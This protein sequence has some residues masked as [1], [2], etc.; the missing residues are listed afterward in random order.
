MEREKIIYDRKNGLLGEAGAQEPQEGSQHLIAASF[1]VGCSNHVSSKSR[2]RAGTKTTK[3]RDIL[4]AIAW[5]NLIR[6]IKFSFFPSTSLP[7]KGML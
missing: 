6:L 5:N 4:L 2:R 1:P 7:S 3:T